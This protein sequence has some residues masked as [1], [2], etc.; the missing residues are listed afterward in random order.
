MVSVCV[1]AGGELTSQRS[2]ARS[3]G[4]GL[5]ARPRA[6]SHVTARGDFGPGAVLLRSY[7]TAAPHP[8]MVWRPRGKSSGDTRDSDSGVCVWEEQW[9]VASPVPPFSTMAHVFPS[10]PNVEGADQ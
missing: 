1:G 7:A 10:F 5:A 3:V 6:P 8:Q 9:C 2:G 4:A